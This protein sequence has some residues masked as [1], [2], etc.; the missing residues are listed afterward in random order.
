MT[1]YKLNFKKITGDEIIRT[2]SNNELYGYVIIES[3]EPI[4]DSVLTDLH[5]KFIDADKSKLPK[6]QA[7]LRAK[8]ELL[9]KFVEM[10]NGKEIPGRVTI[11][12]CLEDEI[13]TEI[14]KQFLRDDVPLEQAISPFVKTFK[15]YTNL[16]QNKNEEQFI[17]K[18]NNK[19]ILQFIKYSPQNEEDRIISEYDLDVVQTIMALF[20]ESKLKTKSEADKRFDSL[21]SLLVSFKNK[22]DSKVILND[23]FNLNLDHIVYDVIVDKHIEIITFNDNLSFSKDIINT[24]NYAIN[25]NRYSRYN[26]FL[27][28]RVLFVLCNKSLEQNEDIIIEFSKSYYYIILIW[29]EEINDDKLNDHIV[30]SRLGSQIGFEIPSTMDETKKYYKRLFSS[31]EHYIHTLDKIHYSDFCNVIQLF[32]TNNIKKLNVNTFF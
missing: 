26:R 31:F 15:Y 30:K 19:R 11:F 18:N 20:T 9:I 14:Q 6:R 16:G 4:Y 21:K 2:Y 25:D 7:Y 32:V 17:L 29:I 8:T 1:L 13:P 22:K 5:L 27:L 28:C 10:F 23:D 24:I 12:E 3:D